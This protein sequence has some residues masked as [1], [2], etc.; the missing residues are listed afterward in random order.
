MS[1]VKSRLLKQQ[2]KVNNFEERKQKLENKKFHKAIK[3]YKQQEK[4]KEK[5][6]NMEDISKFKKQIKDKGDVDDK[7]IEKL[8]NKGEGQKVRGKK[9]KMMENLRAQHH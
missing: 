3:A 4:H 1:K 6:Q 8:F 7:D 2:V 9:P 5:R